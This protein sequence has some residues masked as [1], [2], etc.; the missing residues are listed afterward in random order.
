[1]SSFVEDIS[2]DSVK[3]L[4][5]RYPSLRRNPISFE[6]ALDA[7]NEL[8]DEYNLYSSCE[9][10][11][12]ETDFICDLPS[13]VKKFTKLKEISVEGARFWDMNP[14]NFPDTIEH[15]ALD[16]LSNLNQSFLGA[17]KT[18]LPRLQTLTIADHLIQVDFYEAK[19]G[20]KSAHEADDLLPFIPSLRCINVVAYSIPSVD[21][22][23]DTCVEYIKNHPFFANY[24]ETI[25]GI[26]CAPRGRQAIM[27]SIRLH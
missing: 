8:L 5:I 23:C 18:R 25:N 19:L 11:V 14:K 12:I 21:D 27:V 26:D 20:R 6:N 3:K 17:L 4:E 9:T 2:M 7:W 16:E 13:N 1:M 24:T 10:L 22:W 15:I